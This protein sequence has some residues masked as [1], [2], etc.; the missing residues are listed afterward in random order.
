MGEGSLRIRKFLSFLTCVLVLFAFLAC[1]RI[2]QSRGTETSVNDFASPVIQDFCVNSTWAGHVAQ[3]AFNVT[4]SFTLEDCTF[5]CNATNPPGFT[6]QSMSLS[7]TQSWANFTVTLPGFSCYVGFNL[8][9]WNVKSSIALA[10]LG[11]GNASRTIEVYAAALPFPYLA[12]AISLVENA[13]NWTAVSTDTGSEGYYASVVLDQSSTASIG[14][15]IDTLR[16]SGDWLGVL[17]DCAITEKLNLTWANKQSDIIWALENNIMVGHLPFTDTIGFDATP[18]FSPEDK[19]A[20]YGYYYAILYDTDLSKWNVTSA[21]QQFNSSVYYSVYADGGHAMPMYAFANSTGRTFYNRYYDE[22]GCTIDCYLLFYWLLNVTDALKQALYWWNYA[23]NTFW[24]SAHQYFM[25]QPGSSYPSYEC[26]APFFLKIEGILKYYSPNMPNYTYVLTDIG[27]R[28]LG[29]EWTSAQWLNDMSQ[30][31]Y[32]SVHKYAGNPQTRLVNTL[33]DWQALLGCYLQLNSTYR[34]NLKD[35]LYGNNLNGPAWA[36]LLGSSAGLFNN[37]SNQ[38]QWVSTDSSTSSVA[39]AY[40]EI[41]M[42]VMGVVPGTSTVA[43]PL[44]ELAYE[45]VCDIDPQLFQFNLSARTIRIAVADE[46]SLTFQY[47]VS[48][49]TCSLNQSGVW[50]VVFSESWNMITSLTYVSSLPTNLIYFG[51]ASV[52]EF[53]SSMIL[54]LFIMTTF[55]GVIFLKK[56]RSQTRGQLEKAFKL[57]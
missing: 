55:F 57:K 1:E 32:V 11:G 46:G 54:P 45:Y 15:A 38:F 34:N 12:S 10:S 19:W 26:E 31:T 18:V 23:V 43:F 17:K 56:K 50:Q 36:L 8:W 49:L 30:T 16:N 4:S 33:G 5:A 21:Y 27:N 51:V 39:S 48:P 9:V 13:N 20:L 42:F 22:C 41:L 29:N 28:F 37:Y 24:D 2:R 6:N 40:A 47:G 7:G 35:M 25:Y 14:S 52:P 53:P 44:E 3:F